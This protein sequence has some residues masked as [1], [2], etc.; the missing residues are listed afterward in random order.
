MS[1]ASSPPPGRK[2]RGPLSA[3]TRRRLLADLLARAEGGDVAA[4]EALIR[5][6]A[7][8][9]AACPDLPRVTPASGQPV[10][11]G[12]GVSATPER[13]A[14]RDEVEAATLSETQRIG[15]TVPN[16][17]ALANRFLGRGASPATLYRW[18]DAAVKSGTPGRHLEHH[19]QRGGTTPEGR[20]RSA[21]VTAEQLEAA[22]RRIRASLLASEP[23]V[24]C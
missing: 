10:R 23:E 16:K 24:P 15:G 19:V 21:L 5:L 2:A 17:L 8:A 4:A 20:R 1:G 22:A 14:L 9:E 12:G 7:T 11:R 13:A 3:A 6:G 18:V